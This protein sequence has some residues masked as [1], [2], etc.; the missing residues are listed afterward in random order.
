MTTHGAKTHVRRIF[1]GHRS[2][3]G[4]PGKRGEMQ[5]RV[6]ERSSRPQKRQTAYQAPPWVKIKSIRGPE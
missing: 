6:S 1:P 3:E 2:E 4:D 5:V